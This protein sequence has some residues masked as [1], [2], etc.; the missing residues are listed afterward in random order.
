MKRYLWVF[1]LIS[2]F[3]YG[4]DFTEERELVE[5]KKKEIFIN[6]LIF[7]GDEKQ[8]IDVTEEGIVILGLEVPKKT[9]FKKEMSKFLKKPLTTDI[10]EEIKKAVV[11]Y[12]EKNSSYIVSVHI[13]EGQDVTL[14]NIK[15]LVL[16]GKLGK[17]KAEG[18]RFF[19]NKKIKN[20][21]KIKTE[22]IINKDQ[23]QEEVF[24]LNTSPFHTTSLI[25]E[26]GEELGETNIILQTEDR[27]PVKVYGGY[28]NTGT[29]DT[30]LSRYIAG[31]TIA[32]CFGNDE[33]NA[34]FMSS[35][36]L[37]KWWG[38]SGN[39]IANLW[40]RNILRVFGYYVKTKPDYEPDQNLD[41]K[42]WSLI[43]RY[44][45]PLP[46]FENYKHEFVLGYDFKR[47][48]NFII[49]QETLIYDSFIDVSQFLLKYEGTYSKDRFN[50][51]LGINVF[52]SPGKMTRYNKRKY[53]EQ[54]RERAKSNYVYGL[55][56]IDLN[57]PL[58]QKFSWIL[59]TSFQASSSKLLPIEQFSLGGFRTVRGYRENEVIGDQ[60]FLL[61]NEIRTDAF[62]LQK[63]GK[64]KIQFLG[65]IDFGMVTDV[66]KNILS[67]NNAR[68]L[69]VGPGLRF[70]IKEYLN[71]RVDY[72]IQLKS[73]H[74]RFFPEGWHS[75]IHAGIFLDF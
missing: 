14:G 44:V 55:L 73:I 34:Q 15:I 56:D 42:A 31:V 75:R 6:S 22:E 25:F 47:T 65:F 23:I 20:S 29:K 40:K 59:K 4:E 26:P 35:S 51:L 38:V 58:P 17:I 61:V 53:F 69:S 49:Y 37:N 24:W 10:L 66:D 3:G 43:G 11:D 16:L 1:L 8:K 18:A 9:P 54:E 33:A 32:S 36:E 74:G 5:N 7:M 60:G 63:D 19:S 46:T 41:G 67:K 72:G 30:G 50:A 21:L 28:E 57:I 2:F 39:Y 71:A 45:I 64:Q 27:F 48:N 70:S 12:Y 68:L 52:I 13:L 62:D